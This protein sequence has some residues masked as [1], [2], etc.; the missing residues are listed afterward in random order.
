MVYRVFVEKKEQ[1]TSGEAKTTLQDA[2]SLLGIKNLTKVRILNR[3]DAENISK[4]LFEYAKNTV[5][6]CH[7]QKNFT[8][9]SLLLKR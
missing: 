7:N 1:F 2:N 8:L 6:T 9:P 5:F 4:E 3:Y